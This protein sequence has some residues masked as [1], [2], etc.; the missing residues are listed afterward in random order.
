MKIVDEFEALK[1]ELVEQ[2]I[3]PIYRGVEDKTTAG[4]Q[5]F[6]QEAT[7]NCEVAYLLIQ[8]G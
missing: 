4:L 2:T 5:R 1:K 8:L 3:T 7:K 6:N